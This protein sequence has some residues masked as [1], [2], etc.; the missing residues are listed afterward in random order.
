MMVTTVM[1]IIT[2]APWLNSYCVSGTVLRIHCIWTRLI[3]TTISKVVTITIPYRIIYSDIY[4]S[5]FFLLF[6]YLL[7]RLHNPLHNADGITWCNY[8]GKLV[9]I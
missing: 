8:Y 5:I 4:V 6:I 7:L 2:V 1:P 9:N 3:L